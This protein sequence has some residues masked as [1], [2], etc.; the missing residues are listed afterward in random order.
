MIETYKRIL[1]TLLHPGTSTENKET[2]RL[3]AYHSRLAHGVSIHIKGCRHPAKPYTKSQRDQEKVGN[4]QKLAT[5]RSKVCKRSLNLQLNSYTP[6]Y[7]RR[8]SLLLVDHKTRN[9]SHVAVT[10]RKAADQ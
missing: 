10:F 1:G 7:N 2:I 5:N 6:S 8:R 4:R 9:I 3:L